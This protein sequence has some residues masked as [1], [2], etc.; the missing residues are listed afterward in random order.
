MVVLVVVVVVVVVVMLM[1]LLDEDLYQQCLD[2]CALRPDLKILPGGDMT[3]I[4]EKVS[5]C[6]CWWWCWWWWWWW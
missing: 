5:G 6:C 4:G 3:E 1:L 2:H